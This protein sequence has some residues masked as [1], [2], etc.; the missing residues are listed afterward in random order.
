L[1]VHW[2]KQAVALADIANAATLRT[3]SEWN[4]WVS[5]V[6]FTAIQIA[7]ICRVEASELATTAVKLCH[8]ATAS[9]WSAVS[10]HW[11]ANVRKSWTVLITCAIHSVGHS[12]RT[13][14]KRVKLGGTISSILAISNGAS[15]A[16]LDE[17]LKQELVVGERAILTG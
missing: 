15:L 5:G 7:E 3:A 9:R 6:V 11:I 4:F 10:G 12:I 14:C 17:S 8:V 1:Q 2:T 16:I 13:Q